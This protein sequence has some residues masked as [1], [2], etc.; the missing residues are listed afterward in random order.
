MAPGR[1]RRSSLPST[2]IWPQTPA[3]CSRNS[4]THLAAMGVGRRDWWATRARQVKSGGRRVAARQLSWTS[5]IGYLGVDLLAPVA[6]DWSQGAWVDD[7]DFNNPP[8]ACPDDHPPPQGWAALQLRVQ[9]GCQLRLAADF[10]LFR[11]RSDGQRVGSLRTCTNTRNRVHVR[12]Y[13]QKLAKEA[14][15]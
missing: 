14:L 1:T 11:A 7:P 8:G 9:K 5:L 12:K 10:L 3:P 15:P 6:G 13:A 2:T 4:V